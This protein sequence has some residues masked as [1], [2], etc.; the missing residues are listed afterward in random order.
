[1]RSDFI[2]KRDVYRRR[3]VTNPP[4]TRDCNLIVLPTFDTFI[5]HN[6]TTQGSDR[7]DELSQGT[8]NT[9][10]SLIV[11][12]LNPLN[13]ANDQPPS[14]SFST[15]VAPRT[16]TRTIL[17]Y[18]LTGLPANASIIS[19]TLNLTVN[20]TRAWDG[21]EDSGLITPQ[22]GIPTILNNERTD[23]IADILST[24]TSQGNNSTQLGGG[25]VDGGDGTTVGTIG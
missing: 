21:Q 6:P 19:A 3:N 13:D 23:E 5:F 15:P 25:V 2:N 17:A 14:G 22:G 1:M 8:P 20:G 10:T 7:W 12:L 11:G 9:S 24:S 16:P 4:Q 18:G